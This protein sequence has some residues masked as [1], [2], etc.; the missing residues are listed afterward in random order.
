MGIGT[1]VVLRL[2]CSE[3]EGKIGTLPSG[4]VEG[5]ATGIDAVEGEY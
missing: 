1:I 5:L 4:E 2:Y 3:L